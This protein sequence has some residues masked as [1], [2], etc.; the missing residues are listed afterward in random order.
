MTKTQSK[1]KPQ[2]T[3]GFKAKWS[4][5][6]SLLGRVGKSLLFPIATLPIAAILLRIG[7]QLPGDTDFAKFVQKMITGGGSIVFD[8]LPIIFAVGIGFGLAKDN[9]GEAALSALIGMLLLKYIMADG[10]A[11]LT[12]QIYKKAHDFHADFG[13]KY[14]AIL[15]NNVLTGFVAGG[16]VAY[17]Y[18]KFNGVELPAALG[19]FSGRRLI[20][21]IT[22]LAILFVGI[23]YAIVFPW[24]GF[25]LFKFSGALGD[26]TGNRWGNAAI[27]MVYGVINRLL[28]PF[29]MHHIPNT[30][31]WFTLGEGTTAAGAVVNG[32]INIFLNAEPLH[33]NAGTFQSGFFPIMMFGLPALAAAFYVT[34]DNKQQ[35]RR[36]LAM[37]GSAAVVSFLS[38][39]TEPI[40]F[41]FLF[42]APELFIAHAL[43][44][45]I[46][47]FITG[48]FGIQLG[49]GFSAGLLD[50]MLSIPKS[51]DI[52]KANKTGIDAVM[53]NPAWIWVIGAG[54]AATYFFGAKFAIKRFNLATP[55]RGTNQISDDSD[56]KVEVAEGEMSI[57]AQKLVLGFGGWDNIVAYQHCATRLRYDL[58]DAKKIDE[59]LL[60]EGGAIGVMKVSNTHVQA[61]IGPKVEIVNNE[62]V[63]HKGQAISIAKPKAKTVTKKTVTKKTVKATK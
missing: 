6:V 52:I 13:G 7:A 12:N 58:K 32:D 40:E 33:N 39:I 15:S 24:I 34:A 63:S 17:L 55:G 48:A 57:K 38:G 62:I 20:P 37:F 14:D 41:A 56:S 11:D 10:G 23:V 31:F 60:K 8:N 5:F 47:G 27:M 36:V 9:R 1:T 51:M 46:F 19:F 49:F 43:M 18:N 4:K 50:Y 29:G 22:I 3:H 54:A 42:V 26:A 16:L 45:G 30:L 61:I 59:K 53:A 28:L 2:N 21:V 35:K 44:T 25:G